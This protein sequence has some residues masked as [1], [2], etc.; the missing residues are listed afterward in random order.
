M[1]TKKVEV[2]FDLTS[3][4]GPFLTLDDPVSG[5]LDNTDWVLG[6]S[7]LVDVTDSVMSYNINRG[8]SREL[9]RYQTGTASVVFDNRNRDFDPTYVDSPYYGNIIPRRDLRITVDDV[10]V[11]RG[12]IDDWNLNYSVSGESTTLGVAT[13]GFS[14]LSKQTLTGH[15]AT[16]QTSG[17]RINAI[18]DRAEVAWP[19]SVRNI[20][21]GDSTIGADVISDDANVLQYLQLIETSEQGFLFIDREG[22][23]TFKSRSYLPPTSSAIILAD[24]G[25]GIPYQG[26]NVVYGSELLY[27]E[28][29][30]SSSITGATAVA[31]DID[32]QNAY[33]I[34]NYTLTDLPL[35]TTDQVI[36]MAVFLA[37]KYSQPEYR[38]ESVE[39]LL[40]D[41]DAL[42]RADILSLE[43]G[44][45]VR[46]RFTPNNIGDPIDKIAQVI[47]VTHNAR[48]DNYSVNLGFQT[49]DFAPLVLDDGVFGKLDEGNALSF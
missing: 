32:S 48:I 1:V 44:D 45:L 30:I 10:V 47:S 4:G 3:A 41:L 8:K 6:G 29:V 9:D 31:A 42:D 2:G 16:A 13:D 23:L 49:I 21:T 5:Q 26:M 18:L 12:V 15:T 19:S 14:I 11:Y 17:A 27:N 46:I 24:D 20:D 7:Y 36:D 38:F 37:S 22:T 35:S 28:V 40:D 25:S 33:G 39:I 34:A 43:F